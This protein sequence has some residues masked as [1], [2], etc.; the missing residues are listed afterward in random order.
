MSEHGTVEAEAGAGG[1][2]VGSRRAAALMQYSEAFAELFGVM[3]SRSRAQ[4]G[5]PFALYMSSG[6]C[7]VAPVFAYGAARRMVSLLL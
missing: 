6:R 3:G 4:L 1:N 5:L 2:K 7:C